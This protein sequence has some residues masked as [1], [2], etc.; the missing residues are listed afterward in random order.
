[1]EPDS[2]QKELAQ[3]DYAAPRK[4]PKHDPNFDVSGQHQNIPIFQHI[5]DVFSEEGSRIELN[6][7]EMS[8]AY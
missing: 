5:L 4:R 2:L 8:Q 1:M 3:S 6:H 7:F